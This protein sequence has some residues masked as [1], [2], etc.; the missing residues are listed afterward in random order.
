MIHSINQ[1]IG[2]GKLLAVVKYSRNT[3]FE[4]DYSG[5]IRFED[6]ESEENFIS[7]TLD[8][9]LNEELAGYNTYSN[10]S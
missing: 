1:N 8:K 4:E 2:A 6:V 7:T 9:Y 5:E 10:C 3:C